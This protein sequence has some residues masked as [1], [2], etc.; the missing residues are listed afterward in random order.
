MYTE[1]QGDF[2]NAQSINNS[3]T[4][5]HTRS[6]STSILV[7]RL[8]ENTL[9]SKLHVSKLLYNDNE[10]STN[11]DNDNTTN[12][13]SSNNDNHNNH[14]NKS[15]STDDSKN[16]NKIHNYNSDNSNHNSNSNIHNHNNSS[17][18]NNQ[19]MNRSPKNA[20]KHITFLD[21]HSE[22]SEINIETDISNKN[23]NNNDKNDSKSL[24]KTYCTKEKI[25]DR[26]ENI[27]ENDHYLVGDH[28][29]DDTPVEKDKYSDKNKH[30]NGQNTDKNT[31]HNADQNRH[32]SREY[33][34]IAQYIPPTWDPQTAFCF[35]VAE[36]PV[37][38]LV[39]D[40][41]ETR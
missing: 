33:Q 8:L 32:Q 29:L 16:S 27:A 28:Y 6:R 22:V 12:S 30:L 10:N 4:L 40:N 14:I 25:D 20:E 5:K 19:K 13:T 24:W 17:N 31:L 35:P 39:P 18:N 38:R 26:S 9:P 21:R 7:E 41:L 34:Y 3:T 37:V 11:S 15:H 1:N 23:E 36:L 2:S